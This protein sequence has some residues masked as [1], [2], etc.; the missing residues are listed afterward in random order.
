M[1]ENWKFDEL[2]YIRPDY[3]KIIEDLKVYIRRFDAAKDFSE[4]LSIYKEIE[5]YNAELSEKR[6]LALIRYTL[7]TSDKF[8]EKEYQNNEIEAQNIAKYSTELGKAFLRSPFRKDFEE[9]YGE[10]ISKGIELSERTFSEDNIELRKKEALLTQEYESI[11][12]SCKIDFDGKELNLYGIVKYF[13]DE[14]REVRRAAFR[15][16]SN[17]FEKN[18]KRLEEIWGELIEI[19][20]EM[21]RNLGFKNFVG[22]GHLEQGRLD[23]GE[24]EIRSFREQVLKHIVPLCERLYENQRE[25][26]GLSELYVYDEKMVFN[27]G[28]AHPIGDDDFV[29]E[30]ARKMYHELS[31]ETKEFIDFMIKHQLLDLKNRKNKAQTGYMISLIPHKAPFVFSCFNGT[32]FDVHVLTHELG[33]AFAGYMAM[34]EQELSVYYSETTDI[35]EIHSMAMEQFAYPYAERFFGNEAD[36]FRFQ[37]LQEAITF[38]PFG[39]AVDE[40]Q[41]ICYKNPNL[42]PKERTYEWHKL[43]KKYMPWRKYDKEDEFMNRGGYWYH[44]LHIFQYPMYYI[45]YTLTT[46]AAMEFK[47]KYE[48]NREEALKDY[49]RLCKVGGSLSYLNTLSYANLSSPF[50]DGVVERITKYVENI[51]QEESLKYNNRWDYII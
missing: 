16:Y 32:I 29:M 21:G 31:E 18:E 24:N 34:R 37:H 1:E 28:N 49:L 10:M 4:A 41:H 46:M 14:D 44:K 9:K 6:V 15:A 20:N 23:Y 2:E 19:R 12:A 45:N 25:R 8:Y 33:H 11:M 7:N 5:K 30:E 43:E 47:K 40:F 35:A 36:K 22:L 51:L 27:D 38:V 42:T 13:E 48:E 39:V 3:Q 26:L 50:E 17:F